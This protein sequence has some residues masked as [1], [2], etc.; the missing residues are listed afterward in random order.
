MAS[1]TGGCHRRLVTGT[2]HYRNCPN[3]VGRGKTEALLVF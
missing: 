1:R 3:V 2:V